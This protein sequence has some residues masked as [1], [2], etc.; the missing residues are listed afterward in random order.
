MIPEELAS[1]GEWFRICDRDWRDPTDDSF[2]QLT[3]GRWNPP[4]SWRTLYLCADV[5]TARLNLDRFIGR[6]PYEPEDLDDRL[7]P[8]LTTVTLPRD[9][10]VAEVHSPA[11]VRAVGLPATFP[12]DGAGQLV[13]HSICQRIGVR[14]RAQGLRGVHC[15]SAQTPNGAGRE[16]AWFPATSRSR[17]RLVHRAAFTDWFWA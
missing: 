6:W 2:A 12:L 1:R 13:A 14:I 3:G 4:A 5:V 11:G 16:L 15:R 9:Q 8:D 10:T 17:A 7:G